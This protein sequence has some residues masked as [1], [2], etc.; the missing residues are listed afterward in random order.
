MTDTRLT[1]T[2]TIIRIDVGANISDATEVF[3]IFRKPSGES[4]SKTAILEA[5]NRTIRYVIP[6][7]FFNERGIWYLQGFV[8]TP[9]G[10]WHTRMGKFI[11][12]SILEA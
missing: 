9:T 5:D 11:V 12:E 7:D 3:T 8:K 1:D 2:G 10:Q 4:E 6:E